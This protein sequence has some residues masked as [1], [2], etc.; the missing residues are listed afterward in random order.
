MKSFFSN[1]SRI[2]SDVLMEALRQ[3][4]TPKVDHYIL[5]ALAKDLPIQSD[6]SLVITQSELDAV[7]VN[8][9]VAVKGK[10]NV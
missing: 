10:D 1:G 8:M 5:P 9:L 4:T 3:V 6:D 2:P 7:L